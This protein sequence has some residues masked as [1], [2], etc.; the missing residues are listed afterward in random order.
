MTALTHVTLRIPASPSAE[1][2]RA[3]ASA[4]H[5]TSLEI[6]DARLDNVDASAFH[7]LRALHRLAISIGVDR[8]PDVDDVRERHTVDGIISLLSP[9][10]ACFEISG[11]IIDLAMIANTS[12]P[13][14]T[15]FKIT[16]H[17]PLGPAV[18]AAR[19]VSL[20]PRLRTLGFDFTS[21][22]RYHIP[23]FILCPRTADGLSLASTVPSLHTL[24]LSNISHPA[25]LVLDQLPPTLSVLHVHALTDP[26]HPVEY[27]D[28]PL[29]WHPF[30]PL[31]APN[32][33]YALQLR[34][35]TELALTLEDTPSAAL[36]R[37]VARA[38]P[39]LRTLELQRAM[40]QRTF[41]YHEVDSAWDPYIDALRIFTPGLLIFRISLPFNVLDGDAQYRPHSECALY[42]AQRL[43]QLRIIG[44]LYRRTN[45]ARAN[46][47]L[48]SWHDFVITRDPYGGSP[49]ADLSMWDIIA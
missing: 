30:F 32:V 43:P 20:M 34:G 47:R 44:L 23:P 42:F 9:T 48:E 15:T 17:P 12:W 5:L 39:A 21:T 18:H 38:C 45:A 27:W 41:K 26:L 16:G 29:R 33:Q 14:L 37:A 1:L 49:R 4:P 22:V 11:D 24:T 46:K 6:L 10:I 31:S 28:A 19:V 35:L 3:I 40:F 36:V 7:P 2:L 25:D 8:P 13:N